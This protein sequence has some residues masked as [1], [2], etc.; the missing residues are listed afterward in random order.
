MEAVLAM[1]QGAQQVMIMAHQD[2]DGDA[3]G[4]SLGLM[5]LL[6]G[7]GKSARVHSA[8]PLPDNYL[9]LPGSGQI[10]AD[11][12]AA[13]DIDLAVLL[14][15]HQAERAGDKA[16]AFLAS[17]PKVAVVDHHLGQPQWDAAWVETRF[18]ATCQ[19][20]CLLARRAGWP[21]EPRAATCFF[22]GLQDDTGSFRYSNT[23]PQV[24][25]LAAELVAA[26]ADPWAISSEAYA[27]S[28]GRLRLL[29]RVLDNMQLLAGGRLALA[30]ASQADLREFG[31]RAQDLD[32]VVEELRAVRG[33]EISALLREMSG[34]GVKVSLRSKGRLNVADLALEL[35]GG[36]H[37]RAA[38][39]KLS[40]DLP[41]AMDM[42]GQRLGRLVETRP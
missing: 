21:L 38:G 16:A 15:C 14:D 8:G 11:P 13:G 37:K 27:T 35:G 26:G 3:L 6:A 1:L 41:A 18:A 23:S 42:L 29:G 28:A 2:P 33:V 20:I 40:M 4:A 22:A 32:R 39:M 19:M 9:F 17:A 5:H 12:F 10:M 24:L 34:G 36:G 30:F 31:C 25:E 7:Q